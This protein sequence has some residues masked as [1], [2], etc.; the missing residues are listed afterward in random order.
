[1][2]VTLDGVPSRDMLTVVWT[3]D[4]RVW[5]REYQRVTIE[6]FISGSRGLRNQRK[7]ARDL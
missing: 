3:R 5:I 7:I 4:C 1:M 2:G 6:G